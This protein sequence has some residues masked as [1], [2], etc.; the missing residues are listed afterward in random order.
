MHHSAA[1]Q[2]GT[3]AYGDAHGQREPL[4]SDEANPSD[5]SDG[6]SENDPEDEIHRPLTA[7]RRRARPP[8]P[9]V[10]TWAVPGR[11]SRS[12]TR[13]GGGWRVMGRSGNLELCRP[14]A[15]I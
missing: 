2:C 12:G 15:I 9:L 7:Y 10:V 14:G 1:E 11:C 4:D 5:Q 8:G 3:S 13:R 6:C